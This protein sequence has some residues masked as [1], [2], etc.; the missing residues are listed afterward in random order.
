M[1]DNLPA[2]F[3]RVWAESPQGAEER[4][5]FS[6]CVRFLRDQGRDDLRPFAEAL[7]AAH[8]AHQDYRRRDR[9][10]PFEREAAATLAGELAP[11]IMTGSSRFGGFIE[12]A[13]VR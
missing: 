9:E 12:H 13:R 8:L 7:L 1:S 4:G 10:E 3:A 5:V 2:E 6:A 11:D